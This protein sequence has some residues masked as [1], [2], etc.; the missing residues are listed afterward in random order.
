M[1]VIS[2]FP[3]GGGAKI[4]IKAYAVVGNLPASD[5]E[6]AVAIITTTAIGT[7]YASN[8]TPS[9]PVS[10]DVWVLLGSDNLAEIDLGKNI[11]VPARVVYQYSGSVWIQ[12]ESYVY[13]GSVWVELTM[14][15]YYYG[16]FYHGG[17]FSRASYSGGNCYITLNAGN[18]QVHVN[19][20]SDN[21]GRIDGYT[22]SAIDLTDIS[23]VKIKY[24][25]PADA[26]VANVMR[27][28]VAAVRGSTPTAYVSLARSTNGTGTLDVSGLSGLYYIGYHAET[29]N[30]SYGMNGDHYVYEFE[31]EAA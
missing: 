17:S 2:T 14:F 20:D 19:N 8:S 24:M 28:Q 27:L 22:T 6:G 16:T 3:A 15:V 11:L 18:I 31:L 13:I 23:A 12:L 7:V 21:Y 1:G 10:G 30:L 25:T 29:Q 5:K 4:N 26:R 9:A